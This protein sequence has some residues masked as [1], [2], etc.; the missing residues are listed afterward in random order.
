VGTGEGG[1]SIGFLSWEGGRA[2]RTG[3]GM[4]S[5]KGRRGK[6]R[7]LV[8]GVQKEGQKRPAIGRKK[9]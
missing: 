2:G 9:S 6:K 7:N 8:A 4:G 3:E 1:L 5:G